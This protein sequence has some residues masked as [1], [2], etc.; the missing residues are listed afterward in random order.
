VSRRFSSPDVVTDEAKAGK[1]IRF[2]YI[3][4][5]SPSSVASLPPPLP[6]AFHPGDPSAVIVD[7]VGLILI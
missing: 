5:L 7:T 3:A 4:L 1:A 2:A 6:S